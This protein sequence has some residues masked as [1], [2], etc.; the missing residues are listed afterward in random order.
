MICVMY[1]CMMEEIRIPIHKQM[2]QLN[3]YI[4]HNECVMQNKINCNYWIM[5]NIYFRVCVRIFIHKSGV[6]QTN[7]I[8][9]YKFYFYINSNQPVR[10]HVLIGQLY[11]TA[12][13]GQRTFPHIGKSRFI[14]CQ[15][16]VTNMVIISIFSGVFFFQSDV[17]QQA[18][19]SSLFF[20]IIVNKYI[21]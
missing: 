19:T 8:I 4:K 6:R 5:I 14:L 7:I 16:S 18:F 13:T 17:Y 11:K 15:Y 1:S 20:L 2:V 10:E 21:K 12:M 9:S 3:I